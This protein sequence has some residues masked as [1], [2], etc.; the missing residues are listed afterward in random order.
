MRITESRILKCGFKFFS[1]DNR[2]NIRRMRHNMP[3][4]RILS[5]LSKGYY[6]LSFE[7]YDPELGGV[8]D[9]FMV[10]HKCKVENGRHAWIMCLVNGRANYYEI[11]TVQ[12]IIDISYTVFINLDIGFCYIIE[13]EYGFKIGMSKSIH[14]RSKTFNV[15]LPFKWYFKEVFMLERY[16]DMEK[17]LHELFIAQHI[18]GEWFHLNLK[19][20]KLIDQLY[21]RLR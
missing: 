18:N 4:R 20:F 13:S 7:E 17:M 2:I 9:K 1:S 15:K 8:V 14:S 3:K 10:I 11:K 5:I 19:D 16:K 6:K 21:T 12:E